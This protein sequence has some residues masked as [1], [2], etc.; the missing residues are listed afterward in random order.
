MK[1][2]NHLFQNL[3]HFSLKNAK[4]QKLFEKLL[5]TPNCSP[6]ALHAFAKSKAERQ[7]SNYQTANNSTPLTRAFFIRCS[8]TPKERYFVAC[9]SMVACCGKGFALCC[10]PFDAVS[11]PVARYRP[12]TVRSEAI[13]PINFQTELLAMLFKFLLL[14]DK[15]LTVRIRAK[16]EAEARQR[17]NLSKSTAICVARLNGAFYA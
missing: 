4:I 3:Q 17:L 12:I 11:D 2:Y 6:Y 1:H 15:R 13:A 9:S 8:R 10:I 14:G 16:S 7:N 5:T